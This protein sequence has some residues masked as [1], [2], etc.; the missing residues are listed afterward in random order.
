MYYTNK[1]AKNLIETVEKIAIENGLDPKTDD[2][3]IIQPY[4][5]NQAIS[6]SVTTDNESKKRNVSVVVDNGTIILEEKKGTLNVYEK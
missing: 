6:L 2:F 1:E 3:T 4:S 5:D